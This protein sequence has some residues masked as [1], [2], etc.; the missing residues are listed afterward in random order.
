[1][2]SSNEYAP[3]L[4]VCLQSIKEN[5][6][7]DKNYDIV[8]FS[9]SITDYNKKRLQQQI[10]QPNIKLRFANPSYL[11]K[12]KNL[13]I[14]CKYF[15]EE[16]YYRI[17]APLV[18]KGYN[19]ILFTD[20]DLV[21]NKDA[22]EILDYTK[23]MKAPLAAVKDP[24]MAAYVNS[25]INNA[26][27]YAETK[28]KMEDPYLYVNTGVMVFNSKKYLEQDLFDKILNECV[29]NQYILQ[30]QDAISSYMAKEIFHLQDFFSLKTYK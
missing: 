22:A 28:L 16:C 12:N 17:A 7:K 5:A 30:E 20:I 4:S 19:Q 2:S 29:E 18:I 10:E 25:N 9:R 13:Y 1:M 14:A 6:S 15:K 21:Y 11:F 24:I 27:T 3:Y 26:R 8:I 23:Y